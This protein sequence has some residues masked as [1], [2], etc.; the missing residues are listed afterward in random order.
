[1]YGLPLRS[2]TSNTY[3]HRWAAAPFSCQCPMAVF[4]NMAPVEGHSNGLPLQHTSCVE[5]SPSNALQNSL[6]AKLTTYEA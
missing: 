5:S 1:M 2:G 6:F 3:P 4:T